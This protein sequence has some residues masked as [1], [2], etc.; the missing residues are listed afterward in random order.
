MT[1]N[2]N[3]GVKFILDKIFFVTPD[4]II[5]IP[6]KH[7]LEELPWIADN[8]GNIIIPTNEENIEH[9][10]TYVSTYRFAE[11]IICRTDNNVCNMFT[12]TCCDNSQCVS[13]VANWLINKKNTCP[14]CRDQNKFTLDRS[15]FLDKRKRA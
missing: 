14:F 1:I 11:C 2:N 7:L 9:S 13:C 6:T 10:Y 8:K 12:P 3:F 4:G 15:N 5:L